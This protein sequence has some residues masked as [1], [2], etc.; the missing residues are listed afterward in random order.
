MRAYVMEGADRGGIRE[1]PDASIGDYDA[2]VQML[3]CGICSSTDKMLR[4]A[5]F[6][7]G[8]TYPSVLGHESVGRV[9]EVGDR[10]RNFTVGDLVTRPSAYRPDI[11]PLDMYWG[12]LAERGVVTDRA[13]LAA[14]GRLA[15]QHPRFDQVRLP[16]TT[17][18]VLASLSISLSETF[19]VIVRHD[20][21]GKVVGVVGT[22][23]AGLSLVAHAK[24][25]GAGRVVAVGRRPARLD[26]ARQLGAD[27]TVLAGDAAY[28]A[29]EL[30]GL[31]IAFEA[32]GQAEM[33]AAAMGW[34]KPG[35]KCLVYSAPDT[36]AA[37]DLLTTPRDATLSVASTQEAAVLP[38]ILRLV[39]TGAL[40]PSPFLTHQYPF[41][42]TNQAFDDIDRGEVVKAMI[43]FG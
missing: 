13:A 43:G 29:A 3:T 9:T 34:L 1:I 25:L 35:G 2:A 32:S 21:L 17:D 6:R 42:N 36:L 31:D 16:S 23:I 38:G 27:V 7:L 40:D 30:G 19:S 24:L 22:G 33:A 15:G 14:D 28:A 41:A 4:K 5:T 37:L 18:P 20:I 8:V 10:V 11:A 26:L 12:G 39:E